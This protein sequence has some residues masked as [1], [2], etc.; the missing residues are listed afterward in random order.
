LIINIPK[1]H[2]IAESLTGCVI[3]TQPLVLAPEFGPVPAHMAGNEPIE[4]VNV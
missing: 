3:F 4:L 2:G 1:G